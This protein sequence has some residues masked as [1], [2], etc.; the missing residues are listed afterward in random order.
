MNRGGI[1]YLAGSFIMLAIQAVLLFVCAGSI[2]ILRYWIYIFLNITY[3]I[4]GFSILYRVNPDLFNRR[5]ELKKDAKLWDQFI[6]R[7]HNIILVIVIPIIAGLDYG[8]FNWSY[9]NKYFLIPGF[10]LFYLSNIIVLWSMIV[11]NHFEAT[12]RIQ[13]DIG[14]KVICSG[15]YKFVRHPGYLGGILYAVSVPMIFGSIYAYIPAILGIIIFLIR[16]GLEDSTLQKELEG[17]KD[18]TKQTKYRLFPGIW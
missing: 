7:A 1:R 8:R 14:H 17:Y 18:F 6:M 9:L 5:G 12:V 2:N 16:T 4:I 3:S 13:K 15:P 10:V 11:N